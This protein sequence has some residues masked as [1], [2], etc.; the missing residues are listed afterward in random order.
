M[1][2]NNK[3]STGLHI[4]VELD[5]NGEWLN[6]EMLYRKDYIYYDGGEIADN[7][8]LL[9]EFFRF[10][11]ASDYITMNKVQRFDPKQKIHSCSPFSVAFNFTLNPDDKSKQKIILKPSKE[12]KEVNDAKIKVVKI[13]VVRERLDEYCKNAAKIY[14]KEN[15]ESE[16]NIT[17]DFVL[18]V[19]N[20]IL[21]LLPNMEGFIFL[22]EKDYVRVYF[23]SYPIEKQEKYYG[24]YLKENVFNKEEFSIESEGIKYG[25]SGFINTFADGKRFLKHQTTPFKKGVNQR[26][27]EED[28]LVI[29]K[30]KDLFTRKPVIF[31]N[32]L[33][34]VVD[35]DEF[36]T[37]REIVRIFNENGGKL[38]YSQIIKKIFES[39]E[40]LVLANYYLLNMNQTKDG[41]VLNDYDFVS[42]FR[43]K[44]ENCRI[45]NLFNIKDKTDIQLHSIFGFENYV[46]QA[47][48]NNSLVKTEPNYQVAYFG[49][50]KEK[51][52]GGYGKSEKHTGSK[53]IIFTLIMKYR[54]AI[55]D[56]IYKSKISSITSIMFDDMMLQSVMADIKGDEFDKSKYHHTKEYSIKE[57]LNIWF[58]LYNFFELNNNQKRIDMANKTKELIAQMRVITEASNEHLKDDIEFAFASGQLI[59][60]LLDRSESS[61][62]T[63]DLLEPFLQKTDAI[64][65]K[66]AI[67][68]AFDSY[69]HAIK[70]YHGKFAFDKIMSEVMG[71]EP[72]EL[73]M[74]N[75][76]PIILA[77]YFA[78]TV[79]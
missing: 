11:A 67:A 59:N 13:D 32:P 1:Q 56:Y 5:E 7:K 4:F 24:I 14:F 49:E 34:L 30:F 48:F 73:N 72:V 65:F 29:E 47:I 68:R 78:E 15:E 66:K 44:L 25:V 71:Y 2:W 75:L 38:S 70:F 33:P 6:R 61:N 46:I 51:F 3:P 43:Y 9:N 19:K 22:G 28:A 60:Y 41:L 27:T 54:K 23:K 40:N 18:V 26:L 31:P 76:M 16:I 52:I 55:Y 8:L 58:S 42:L 20:E 35:K 79:F 45:E 39:D 36:K 69:K 53:K 62:R 37:N 21:P 10:Q 50:I 63:H 17:K 77:G 74:K 64:L 57:K 12:E